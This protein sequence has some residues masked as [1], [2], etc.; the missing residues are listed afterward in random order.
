MD[1]TGN[2]KKNYMKSIF[3]LYPITIP[4]VVVCL[5]LCITL[6][7]YNIYLALI[8]LI[9]VIIIFIF[10]VVKRNSNFKKIENTKTN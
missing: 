4:S 1:K 7:F 3:D 2:S 9:A 6:F 5:F 8:G 10:A